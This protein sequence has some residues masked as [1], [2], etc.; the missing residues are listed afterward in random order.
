M[1]SGRMT[2]PKPPGRRCRSTSRSCERRW[3]RSASPRI[4]RAIGSRSS[5]TSS[6]WRAFNASS[7]SGQAAR[8]S[9]PLARPRRS[10]TSPTSASPTARSRVS[11]SCD[12]R[13]SRN[14]SSPISNAA[15]HASLVGELETLV[16]EHPLRERLRAQLMLALYRSG[17]QAEALEAYQDAR[18]RR[19]S[20]SSGSSRGARY[21]SCSRRSSS[22]ILRWTRRRLSRSPKPGRSRYRRPR[23]SAIRRR[24]LRRA[25]DGDGPARARLRCER[26]RRPARPRG[27]AR[28][29][30]PRV[31][32]SDAAP[33]RL[34][35]APIETTSG[36]AITAVF[37][38]PVVHE[39]DARRAVR[40]ADEIQGRLSEGDWPA[41]LDVRIGVSHRCGRHRRLTRR[42]SSFAP[43]A[44][45]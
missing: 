10:R 40:A 34:T 44:S 38:L 19:S 4:R 37:G 15:R 8:G 26:E 25:E 16:L 43:P 24:T 21:A 33:W 7:K 11:R 17:R 20:R 6:T 18:A 29:A 31:S 35:R 28:R 39:D 9:R 32:G 22:R 2:H 1:P 13:V 42:G 3:A 30:D 41:R 14:E 27:P 36:D 23:S 5:Q 45:R 12:S